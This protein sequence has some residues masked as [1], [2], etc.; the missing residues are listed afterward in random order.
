MEPQ[1]KKHQEDITRPHIDRH[2]CNTNST[3]PSSINNHSVDID[4]LTVDDIHMIEQDI[5]HGVNVGRHKYSNDPNFK[6]KPRFLKFC[7]KCSRSGHSISPC[8]CKR[9]TK[10]NFKKQIFNQAIKGN[11]NLPKKR[12]T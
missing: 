2:K 3:L 10:P 9:Y 11:Q 1:E 8:P 12:V 7:K 4:H 5:A 6:G